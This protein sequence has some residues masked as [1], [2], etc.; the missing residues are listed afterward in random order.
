MSAQ[1][2]PEKCCLPL[3]TEN[4]QLFMG[5]K[6]IVGGNADNLPTIRRHAGDKAAD[7]TADKGL[8]GK[9]GSRLISTRRFRIWTLKALQQKPSCELF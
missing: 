2:H 3:I 4:P 5:R 7:K 9:A 8:P 6:F 1:S